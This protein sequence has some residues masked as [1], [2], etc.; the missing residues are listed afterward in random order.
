[1]TRAE[2]KVFLA[3]R[4]ERNFRY[5]VKMISVRE[6]IDISEMIMKGL[7][8][9]WPELQEFTDEYT[10]DKAP[11][12]TSHRAGGGTPERPAAEETA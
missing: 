7:I 10:T 1:M 2:D 11:V 12:T 5:G 9:V 4:V 8:T 3:G 6:G